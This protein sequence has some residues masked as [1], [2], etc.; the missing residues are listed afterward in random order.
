[1]DNKDQAM[2]VMNKLF[3]TKLGSKC[4]HSCYVIVSF[5]NMNSRTTL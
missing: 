5:L 3:V 1:L 4:T 2:I